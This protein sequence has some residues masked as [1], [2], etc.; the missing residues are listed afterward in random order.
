MTEIVKSSQDLEDD[1][2]FLMPDFGQ[3]LGDVQDDFQDDMDIGDPFEEVL[4]SHSRLAHDMQQEIFNKPDASIS[5]GTT[6][7]DMELD[8]DVATSD[9]KTSATPTGTPLK[10]FSSPLEDK[11]S[12]AF[13]NL[14]RKAEEDNPKDEAKSIWLMCC[15]GR[16]PNNVIKKKP[17]PNC[18]GYG[19]GM[20]TE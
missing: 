1:L 17:R 20:P 10:G 13:T 9:L 12:I 15:A 14:S 2:D 7:T 5:S 11:A 3:Q 8:E 19:G 18:L 16:S 4:D 6:D